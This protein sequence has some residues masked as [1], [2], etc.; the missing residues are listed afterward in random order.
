MFVVYTW[1]KNG[2][3]IYVGSGT[4]D[5]PTKGRKIAGIGYVNPVK[6]GLKIVIESRHQFRDDAY[7]A[8]HQLQQETGVGLRHRYI[9]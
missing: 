4:E 6:K 2:A 8:E 7:W 1:R 9:Q 5:R 3:I